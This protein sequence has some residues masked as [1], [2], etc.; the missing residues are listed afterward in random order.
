MQG[1][2]KTF[3]QSYFATRARQIFTIP[4]RSFLTNR[5]MA[6]RLEDSIARV[7]IEW[8]LGPKIT[9]CPRDHAWTPRTVHVITTHC[10]R[11]QP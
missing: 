2:R 1:L 9:R 5:W 11:V 3:A 10:S 8:H 4:T 6:V 7:V